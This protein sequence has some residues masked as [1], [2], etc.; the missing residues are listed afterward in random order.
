MKR[1]LVPTDFS[2]TARNA[3]EYAVHLALQANA[4]LILFHA[5]HASPLAADVPP[6]SFFT[7][8]EIHTRSDQS[9]QAIRHEILHRHGDTLTVE[10][11]SRCGFAVDEIVDFALEFDADLIVMGMQGA[12]YISET[13][14]GSITTALLR[15]APCPVLVIDRHVKFTDIRRIVLACDYVQPPRRGTFE[16][17]KDFAGLFTSPWIYVVNV[18]GK[19][20]VL[21]SSL[22]ARNR[23]RVTEYLHHEGHSFHSVEDT[24]V[25]A[26]LKR[27][28]EEKQADLMVMVPRRYSFW[29]GIFYAPLIKRM[30]FHTSVPLLIFQP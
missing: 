25:V 24:D 26:G 17:L 6:D 21:V 16:A 18:V 28:A 27:F 1:I 23:P 13:V 3:V 29:R 7:L 5:Y 22:E 8:E 14:I 11:V 2:D 20:A 4:G 15:E 12:G 19:N 10:C 9:L 30:A